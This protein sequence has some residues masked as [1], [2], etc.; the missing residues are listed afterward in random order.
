M[1]ISDT[2]IVSAHPAVEI[3]DVQP[4]RVRSSG[5]IL[6]VAVIFLVASLLTW[7]FSW[8]GRELKSSEISKYLMDESHPRHVQ[9]AL[10]Q[11]QQRI[12]QG[13]PSVKQWY[14]QILVLSRHQEA[15]FR[16]TVAW[17]MGFDNKSGEF[18]EALLRL[19]KDPE[20]IVRRNAALALVRF[21]DSKG[22]HELVEMLQGYAVNATSGGLLA[23]TLQEGAPIE[24]GA[25]VARIEES[26]GR[27]QELR[28]PLNGVVDKLV[29]QNGSHVSK[30]ETILLLKPDE[31]TLWEALRGLALI[32]EKAELSIVRG[33]ASGLEFASA[34]V[35]R[36]AE[37]TAREIETRMSSRDKEVTH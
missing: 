27:V 22:R 1:S 23:S 6:I 33:Y 35:K 28:S 9:H 15:E 36:Q 13:N 7:Y 14:P 29:A 4:G 16:L 8:F 2:K 24:R 20:P 12:E 18:H 32:G 10:L 30:A 34:R 11:I 3:P 26:G 21:G 37:L 31:K 17:L 5:P 19:L 25:L